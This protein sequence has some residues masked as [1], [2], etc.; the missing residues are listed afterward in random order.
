MRAHIDLDQVP[1]LFFSLLTPDMQLDKPVEPDPGNRP[2][3]Q[4]D[5]ALREKLIMLKLDEGD[6]GICLA[7]EA[8]NGNP[9]ISDRQ[10]VQIITNI[11]EFYLTR[12]PAGRDGHPVSLFRVVP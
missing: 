1:T 5:L 11:P 2:V 12:L 9:D 7:A 6:E 8:F 4:R 3:P 10:R